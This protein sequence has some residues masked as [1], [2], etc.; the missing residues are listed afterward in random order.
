MSHVS[1][2]ECSVCGRRHEA[3]KVQTLCECGGPL[4][5]RYDLEKGESNVEPRLARKSAAEYVALCAAASGQDSKHI[6][7][8]GEGLTP[9]MKADRLA[10]RLGA[11]DLWVKDEGANPTGSFKDRGMSCAVSMCVELGLSKIAVASA[12]NAGSALA[13]YAAASGI[14]SAYL[15]AARRAAIE[16][17]RVPRL[18]SARNVGQ[19]ANQR[20]RTHHRRTQA[21]RRLVRYQRAQGAVSHRGKKTMGYE[22][23]EQF[24]WTLPGRDP[25]SHRR[26]RR[27]DRNVESFRRIGSA[28]L[29]FEPAPENDCRADHRLPARGAGLRARRIEDRILGRRAYGGRRAPRPEAAGRRSDARPRFAKAEARPSP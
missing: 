27:P 25:V 13:A 3:G 10:A 18:R 8:L 7:S 5:V 6:V 17:H 22:I 15:R 1:H 24:G 2:L 19:R 26:R 9:I 20:L 21:R 12:G 29:D 16:L 14:G 4:L 11:S 28:G 23:A